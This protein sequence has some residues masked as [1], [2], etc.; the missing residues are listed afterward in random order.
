[1]DRSPRTPS[2]KG[3][4]P[5]KN[6]GTWLLVNDYVDKHPFAFLEAVNV[7]D[8]IAMKAERRTL[9]L[10]RVN[11]VDFS[12]DGDDDSAIGLEDALKL[13]K[14]IMVKGVCTRVCKGGVHELSPG[15]THDSW[16]LMRPS[17]QSPRHEYRRPRLSL[18]LRAV[19]L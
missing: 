8:Q 2:E 6:F 9:A 12:P 1:M 3:K 10:A 13:S 11:D 7:E 18:G 16:L 14:T 5:S 4:C 15:K 19:Q 17:A